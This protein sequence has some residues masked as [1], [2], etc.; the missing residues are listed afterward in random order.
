MPTGADFTC[1]TS[2]QHTF[3]LSLVGGSGFISSTSRSSD[4]AACNIDE[5]IGG[6]QMPWI[7]LNIHFGMHAHQ[8]VEM[9]IGLCC[10]VGWWRWE[11][12]RRW[13]D[14][15]IVS[16]RF[17]MKEADEEQ[18]W[19]EECLHECHPHADVKRGGTAINDR[20]P[21]CFVSQWG[22]FEMRVLFV[23]RGRE[24]KVTKA[25]EWD[26]LR[27]ISRRGGMRR[28]WRGMKTNNGNKRTHTHTWGE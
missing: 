17:H 8:L 23:E 25:G 15:R 20:I 14:S 21:C 1:W 27:W 9:C 10:N 12:C 26:W 3:R 5:T 19:E 6:A 24:A 28:E 7:V 11:W 16:D 13:S 2:L 22:L 4:R 18:T